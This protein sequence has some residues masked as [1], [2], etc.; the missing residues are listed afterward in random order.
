MPDPK[1]PFK[2]QGATWSQ[3]NFLTASN[4]EIKKQNICKNY[5]TKNSKAKVSIH[6]SFINIYSDFYWE[7]F[8][9]CCDPGVGPVFSGFPPLNNR[10]KYYCRDY[11]S[12]PVTNKLYQEETIICG[13]F[14]CHL[15][16]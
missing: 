7:I 10:I 5:I 6:E 12:E 16:H 3:P 2:N 9:E 8:F 11:T 15:H 13:I 4:K 1:G 14:G